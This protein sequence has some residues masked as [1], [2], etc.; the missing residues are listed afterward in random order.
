MPDV[1]KKILIVEDDEQIL[2]I[3]EI[4]FKQEAVE[5]ITATNGEDGFKKLV[6]EKPDVVLLD[7]MLPVRDGFWVLEE[8]KKN[9]TVKNTPIIVLSNLGQQKD[10]DR[11]TELGAKCFLVK[12]DTPI[13]SLIDEVKKHLTGEHTEIAAA[14][15]DLVV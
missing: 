13:K 2:R 15:G 12:A 6:S 9:A 11:A 14:K 3:Y 10:K 5:V 4:K 8:A 7:L 1:K